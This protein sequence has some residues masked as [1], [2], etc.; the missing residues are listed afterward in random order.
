[1]SNSTQ[2][3]SPEFIA[4]FRGDE[5]VIVAA[6]CIPLIVLAVSLRFY[7]RSL[8]KAE[9]GADDYI[10]LVAL[11]CQIGSSVLSICGVKYA[12]S[13][14]HLAALAQ[15]EPHMV[16]R[17][18]KWLLADSFWYFLT[19]GIPK[20]A[21]LAFY[22]RIF[23]IRSYR[24]I[25]YVLMGIV[26]ATAII[27]SII[28]LNLCRPFKYN[29][30]RTIPGG[31]CY[32]ETVFF[33]WGSFPNIVTDVAI[34]VLPM[35]VVWRL[36]TT[37][38]M[39]VGL[40][41]TFLL[42]GIGLAASIVRFDTFFHADAIADGSWTVQLPIWTMIEPNIYLIAA[43][44]MTYNPLLNK[45]RNL[46]IRIKQSVLSRSGKSFSTTEDPSQKSFRSKESTSK[47]IFHGR[48]KMGKHDLESL[49]NTFDMHDDNLAMGDN[50]SHETGDNVGLVTLKH[51]NTEI[52]REPIATKS[53]LG[54]KQI[55]VQK[56]FYVQTG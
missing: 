41:L 16:T 49:G 3:L 40:T 26:V 50:E 19:V 44:L 30:D 20:L 43:C 4:A 38:N 39:K 36:H 42:G 25:V 37:R 12:G 24:I 32:K 33:E 10:I 21:I 56:E 46:T 55:Q 23:T 15:T 28:S 48:R 34:I 5:L 31:S 6:V 27:T 13:G 51:N 47:K 18:F 8:R 11:F 1:M 14:H 52:M 7:C 35:P 2:T 9:W 45:F 53:D 22:L 29:W 54:P 17:F